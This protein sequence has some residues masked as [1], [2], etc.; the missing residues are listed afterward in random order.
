[1]PDIKVLYD[2]HGYRTDAPSDEYDEGVP[3]SYRG[4]TGASIS[5]NGIE[6]VED[7]WL[8]LPTEFEIEPGVQ[9]YL[10]YAVYET[11]DSFGRDGGNT[12]WIGLYRD[13][14]LAEEQAR[15]IE[16]HANGYDRR[17]SGGVD[18][19][20]VKIVSD[21]GKEYQLHTPWNGY[22]ERLEDLRVESVTAGRRFSYSARGY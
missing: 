12:E 2:S 4:A 11:G 13:Y 10:L 22:F 5:V 8:D 1:M 7:G 6:V 21:G 19:Y 17:G 20:S 9:Y 3:Y 18:A 15:K 14:D 16:A